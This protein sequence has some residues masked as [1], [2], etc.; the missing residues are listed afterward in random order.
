MPLA[1]PKATLPLNTGPPLS[2]V[3]QDGP[4]T[5]T[6]VGEQGPPHKEPGGA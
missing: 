3:W 5:V 2:P 6:H 1:I 4:L